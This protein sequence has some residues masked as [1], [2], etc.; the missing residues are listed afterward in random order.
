MS[1]LRPI[2]K[3]ISVQTQGLGQQKKTK[4]GIIYTDKI[5]NP[6]IW[7]TVV[8]VGNKITEDIR[9]GD[10]VLWNLTKNGGRGYGSCDIINQDL[11]IAVDREE[12]D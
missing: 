7:S 4:S 9:V 1:K 11:I 5:T 8:A 2:G 12:K 3:W 10:K 6:N